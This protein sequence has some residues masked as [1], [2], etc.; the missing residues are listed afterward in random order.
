[1]YF[2]KIRPYIVAELNSSHRGKIEVAKKMIDAA[3]ACG[4]NAVKF[5]S[6]TPESLYCK[7]YYVQNP[8]SKRMVKGFSLSSENLKELSDYCREVNIDFSSTPYSKEEVDFLVDQCGSPF[9][10]VA[11]MDV[12]N[13]PFLEYI[14]KKMRPIVMSTGMATVDEIDKAVET[15]LKT[16]NRDICI[17][18][19]VSLY[20]TDAKN[21]N[22][23]NMLM[24]KEKYPMCRVGYSDHTIGYEVACAAV[25]MGAT[26]IEKHFTLDNS[27]IGWD[28]QMATEPAQMAELVKCCHRVYESLGNRERV[29]SEDE[30]KQ[31]DKMRRS[32]VVA[33]DVEKGHALEPSDIDAK[34]PGNGISVSQY[35][36]IIGKQL[37]CDLQKDEMILPDNIE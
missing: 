13:L 17:L 34:R 12:N 10:K 29:L 9:V 27:I 25:A 20:P 2:D 26:L 8:I 35:S 24:L 19:C 7:D 15:I 14:A 4:C 3:K 21:V 18:H 37:V 30:L 5:Q 36:K 22:L 32:L 31:R 6:W 28:N 11:S 23:N 1:M 16:G 33:R